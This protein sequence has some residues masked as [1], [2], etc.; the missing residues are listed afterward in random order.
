MARVA[1]ERNFLPGAGEYNVLGVCCYQSKQ[2]QMSIQDQAADLT[3]SEGHTP[4]N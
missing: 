2:K 3:V 1:V 4:G